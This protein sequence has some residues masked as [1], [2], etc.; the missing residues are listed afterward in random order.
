MKS[1]LVFCLII[2]AI[3]LLLV[4]TELKAKD[5]IS[6]SDFKFEIRMDR[7][8]ELMVLSC[9]EGCAWTNLNFGCSQTGECSAEITERGVTTPLVQK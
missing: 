6:V 4:D 3:A 9:S 2:S 8:N 7:D 1:I 5:P